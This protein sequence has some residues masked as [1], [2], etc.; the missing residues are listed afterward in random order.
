MD[1]SG[2][3]YATNTSFPDCRCNR[4]ARIF[5][6]HQT[7]H[8]VN[9]EELIKEIGKYGFLRLPRK[10]GNFICRVTSDTPIKIYNLF[11]EAG[12]D[13]N[14]IPSTEYNHC[15][16]LTELRTV[17]QNHYNEHEP[18]ILLKFLIIDRMLY[19][20]YYANDKFLFLEEY[21]YIEDEHETRK[22]YN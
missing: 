5:T 10:S 17:L 3:T 12:L 8:H 15:K 13:C 19:V 20:S 4:W 22:L 11:I 2:S 9:C 6:T 1:A 16:S 7:S 18:K 14:M 21:S